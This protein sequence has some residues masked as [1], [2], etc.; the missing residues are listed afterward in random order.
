MSR[1]IY[2]EITIETND[3]IDVADQVFTFFIVEVDLQV[4]AVGFDA[5]GLLQIEITDVVH[6]HTLPHVA[7]D[8]GHAANLIIGVV[9]DGFRRL[10]SSKD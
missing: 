7:V 6:L 3:Q 1:E 2:T 5:H 10:A 8:V 4:V 9:A